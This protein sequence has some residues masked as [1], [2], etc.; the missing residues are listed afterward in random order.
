MNAPA[1][2]L[3]ASDFYMDTASWSPSEVGIYFRLLIWEWVNG[4]IPDDLRKMA[5]IAGCDPKTLDTSWKTCIGEKFI[6]NGCRGREISRPMYQGKIPT[7]NGVCGWENSRLER[8]RKEQQ[9]YREKLANSGRLGGL[10]TQEKKRKKQSKASS[11]IKALQSS[12]SSSINKGTNIFI[13]PTVDQV[14]EYCRERKNNI[15]AET[16][17]AHYSSNGWMV[18]KNRMKDWKSAVITWESRQGGDNGNRAGTGICKPK[19][20]GAAGRAESD[21]MPYPIDREY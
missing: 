11:K 10:K 4:P 12:S 8:T 14:S 18:G 1:F 21:G 20:P 13:I 19:A 5:R 2:Q 15:N 6:I 7:T 9:E 17:V 16:F 3:Y